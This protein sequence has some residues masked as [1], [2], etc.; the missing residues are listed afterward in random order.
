M[1]YVLVENGNI[2]DGPCMLPDSW[3]NISGLK[4]LPEEK[5][6]PLGWR[7]YSFVPWEGDMVR[8]VTV[9]ST[10]EITATDCIERQQ[11]REKTQEELDQE[12]ES[13][14]PGIRSVRNQLLTES[15]WTQLYDSPLSVEKKTEWATYRQDLRSIPQDFSNPHS[16]VWPTPPSD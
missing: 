16:V 6:F 1:R 2:I 4:F 12:I 7:R 13:L 10:F 3:G 9:A 5:L 15:D 8:K 14:W 11:V